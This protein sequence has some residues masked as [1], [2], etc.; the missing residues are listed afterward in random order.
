MLAALCLTAC[1]DVAQLPVSAGTGP[2]PTLP[3][4]RRSLVPTVNIAPAQ[5]WLG[6]SAPTGPAGTQVQRYAQGLDHPRW[7][8]VLPNGD[9]L[10]AETNAPAKPAGAGGIRG[11]IMGLVMKRAGAATPSANRITLLRDTQ[12]K[13]VADQRFVL[14]EGLHSPFG[15]AWVNGA[16]YVANTDAVLRFP[17]VLGETR[18]AAPGVK[19]ADLPAGSINHHWTK[20]LLPSPDGRQ[21]YITVGSN[22]NAGERGVAAEEGRAAIWQFDV[23]SGTLRPFATGLHNPNGMAWEPETG[24]LWTAVNERDELGSDLVPDYLTA[25]H[26][27][28]F[29]GWPYSWYGGHIDSRVQP[30]RPDLVARARVPD[31]ALGPHT[32]SLGLAWSGGTKLPEAYAKGMFV[33]QHGSWNRR[34]HSGYKVVFVPFA[35]GRPSG[36]P[37]DVLTGFLSAD[38]RAFGRPVGVAL[39]RRGALLVADD[40][41]N[42]I[43]R[44]S[45]LP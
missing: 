5:G 27:G 22:S 6:A 31:Y 1:A 32:A 20:S 45:Q 14:L 11:W 8:L 25:V 36:Q 7:L 35:H 41:G 43:W 18:I 29:Y 38:G 10:V 34:P 12:G 21:L 15:M 40:V 16:L 26:D 33:G 4:P 24:L 9:V 42:V 30:P 3:E 13:G 37:V 39:D 17:H 44:V 19:V 23:A 2:A 28:A